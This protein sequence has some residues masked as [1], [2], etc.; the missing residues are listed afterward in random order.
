MVYEISI[1]ELKE[2]YPVLQKC[3]GFDY[4][5]LWNEFFYNLEKEWENPNF[6]KLRMKNTNDEGGVNPIIYG[7]TYGEKIQIDVPVIFE[8]HKKD[9]TALFADTKIIS[10]AFVFMAAIYLRNTNERKLNAVMKAVE[11]STK[12]DEAIRPELLKLFVAMKPFKR[13]GKF[14]VRFENGNTIKMRDVDGW[15][16]DLLDEYLYTRL[17]DIS[18]EEAEQELELMH[19]PQKGVPAKNPERNW[20]MLGSYNMIDELVLQGNGVVTTEQCKILQPYLEAIGV[21]REGDS[22]TKTDTLRSRI[23]DLKKAQKDIVE[24]H[25]MAHQKKGLARFRTLNG[26]FPKRK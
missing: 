9:I 2:I 3:Y 18:Y 12:R 4:K 14:C 21:I 8:E 1:K 20:F 13:N 11:F 10:K 23:S 24:L 7:L 19:S 22:E 17:E 5:E 25:A 26:H 16:S 6:D 15:F